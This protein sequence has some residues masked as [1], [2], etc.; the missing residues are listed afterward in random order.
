MKTLLIIVTLFLV[1]FARKG[2]PLCPVPTK[3]NRIEGGAVKCST[4][5][6]RVLGVTKDKYYDIFYNGCCACNTNEEVDK[7]YELNECPMW[8]MAPNCAEYGNAHVCAY[9]KVT[10]KLKKYENFCYAC[11]STEIDNYLEGKCPS[12]RGI[13][14]L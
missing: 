13:A 2:D 12:L 14:K 10:H 8:K 5:P 6:P 11:V 3:C 9:N 7:W 1:S 4:N